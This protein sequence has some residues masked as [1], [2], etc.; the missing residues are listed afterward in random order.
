MAFTSQFSLKYDS[1]S[2]HSCCDFTGQI[3]ENYGFAPLEKYVYN[4]KKQENAA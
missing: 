2:I 1:F 4:F 3:W